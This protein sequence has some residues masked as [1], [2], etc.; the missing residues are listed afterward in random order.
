[1][2]TKLMDYF[3]KQ[4]RLGSLSTSSKDGKVNVAYFGSPR[5]IDEKTIVMGLGN[6]RT[7][8]YLKENPHGVFMIMEPG[9][10]PTEWKGVR[11]YVK[12]TDCQTEGPKLEDFR[13]QVAKVAG[14]AAAKL[15]HAYVAFEIG[16]IKPLADFGQGWEK[17]IGM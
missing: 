1:M 10:T 9:T 11:L 8:R 17:S 15:I 4:P 12:M 3:N 6:N 5:M 16:E 13:A 7:F 2:S 14:E